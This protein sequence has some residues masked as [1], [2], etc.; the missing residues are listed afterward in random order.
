MLASRHLG[1]AN[2]AIAVEVYAHVFERADY[3]R[4]ASEVLEVSYEAMVGSGR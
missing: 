4:A 3:A 1:H 2:A